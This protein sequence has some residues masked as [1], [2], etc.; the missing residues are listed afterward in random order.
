MAHCLQE[1]SRLPRPDADLPYEPFPHC[2]LV[3][4][5][6]LPAPSVLSGTATVPISI[7]LLTQQSKASS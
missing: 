2:H 1:A 5:L 6:S 4:S 3:G 7:C